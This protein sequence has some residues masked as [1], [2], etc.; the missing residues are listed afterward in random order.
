MLTRTSVMQSFK[1]HVVRVSKENSELDTQ[2]IM[3]LKTS[4]K[5]SG[6]ER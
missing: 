1:H 6:V 3:L 2:R 5:Y 4:L